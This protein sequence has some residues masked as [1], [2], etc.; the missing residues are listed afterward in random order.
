MTDTLE[1]PMP[2][3]ITLTLPTTLR[4]AGPFPLP[5]GEGGRREAPEG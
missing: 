4:V 3:T 5:A 1:A 2:R